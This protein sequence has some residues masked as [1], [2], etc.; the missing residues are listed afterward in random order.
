MIKELKVQRDI[1]ALEAFGST[2]PTSLLSNF[3]PN[4]G[5]KLKEFAQ[6]F[7]FNKEYVKLNS[8][9]KEFLKKLGE[10]NYLD[11]SEFAVMDDI[12]INTNLNN[13]TATLE[14]LTDKLKKVESD[15]LVPYSNYIASIISSD[16]HKFDTKNNFSQYEN[17]SKDVDTYF[18]ELNSQISAKLVTKRKL[19]DLIQRNAD[20]KSILGSINASMENL[21]SV[22]RTNVEKKISE[23]SSYVDIIIGRIKSK[24]MQ[25][26]S[27]QVVRSLAEGAY[28]CASLLEIYSATYY[29]L[30]VAT[31]MSN[32]FM[33][34]VVALK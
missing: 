17:F 30:L 22:N 9:Q 29:H 15:V 23:I 8:S 10:I 2:N 11:V 16:Q 13:F 7:V 1:I 4:I 6:S 28:Q 34:K 31:K 12:G 27:P 32:D 24:E 3:F 25:G 5:K 14:L 20:W 18:K 33:E 21:N 26:V 19:K